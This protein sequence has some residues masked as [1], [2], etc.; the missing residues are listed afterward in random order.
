MKYNLQ[1]VKL[2]A[3]PSGDNVPT[4]QG[5]IKKNSETAT[6]MRKLL[7]IFPLAV[8]YS[9]KNSDHDVWKMVLCMRKISSLAF[10]P[11]L[12]I[13]QIAIL[14]TIIDEYL[15]LRMKCFPKVPL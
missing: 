1:R 8:A 12:S 5:K 11:G 14:E 4:I 6:E 13:G 3:D 7:L 9:I 15:E 2:S 10:A